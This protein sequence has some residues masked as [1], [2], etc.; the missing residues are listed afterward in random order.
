MISLDPNVSYT[1]A[2]AAFDK[3]VLGFDLHPEGGT[4]NF[5]IKIRGN[6]QVSWSHESSSFWNKP[7]DIFP[8]YFNTIVRTVFDTT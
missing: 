1:T 2:D 4:T 7:S 8:D 6:V 3:G 5:R